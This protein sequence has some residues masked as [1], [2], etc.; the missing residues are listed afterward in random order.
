[1]N[2]L[3]S[4]LL[5]CAL[6]LRADFQPSSWKYR[7]PLA[8]AET[9][10]GVVNIDRG[11]YVNAQ[12]GLGDLR[13]VSGQGEL[14]Y[15]LERMSGSRQ[16]TEVSSNEPLN[17]GVTASGDLELTVD[18]GAGQRHN[19]IRLSTNRVNFRQRVG[20]ATSDDGREW[21][22]VRDDGYI[23]DFSQDEQHVSV[24]EAGY[25]VSSRRY[26]RLTV[27]G[28]KDP[29]AVSQCWITLDKNEPPVRDVMA[30]LKAD[31]QQE[32]KTQSTLYTWD[33]GVSIPYDELS[34]NVDTA[35]FQRAATV[36]TSQD[37]KDW[38]RLANGVLS[39][40]GKEESLTVELPESHER[41]LRLRIYNRDDQPLALKTAALSVVRSRLKF[42]PAA[43]ASYWLYYG[44][45]DAHAPS[46]DL[47]DQLAREGPVPEAT[48]LA[49]SE[50]PNAAYREKPAPEKPWSEQHPGV[51]YITLALAVV[52]MGI[53]T[54]R[55]LRKARESE[56]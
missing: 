46:Y 41:Y 32:S 38:G 34:V 56:N 52:S 42:K 40:F 12:P 37:G 20:V 51:L 47:R 45:L 39:R 48:I 28:W 17:Q 49:G 19:G 18:V 53:I 55:F 24:L 6:L 29:K 13:V 2:K 23:F 31:P 43:G 8:A 50:E 11:I 16:R 10:V 1:M 14:P 27:F 3:I 7:R 44:N 35:A 33:L 22:R 5:W 15:V 54:V 9:P 21:L 30:T 26:V 4:S 25:P 36:E